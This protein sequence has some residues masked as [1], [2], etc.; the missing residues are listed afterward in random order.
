MGLD[1][2]GNNIETETRQEHYQYLNSVWQQDNML[3]F[4]NFLHWYNNKDVVPTPK[5]MQNM[6]DFYHYKGIDMLKLGFALTNFANLCL[7]KSTTANF[8]PFPGSDKNLLQRTRQDMVYEPIIVFTRKTVVSET[9][10]RDST[11]LCKS[12]VGIDASR[13]YPFSMCQAMPTGLY[14]RWELDSKS[15]KFKPSQNKTRNFEN[16][17][18]LYFTRIR[19][20]FKVESFH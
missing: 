11:N 8:H 10:F 2:Y 6:V 9:F 12:I 5:I 7:H 18:M 14:T 1:I 3:T 19:P 13:L 16:L 20:Q 17:V 15:G 4:R